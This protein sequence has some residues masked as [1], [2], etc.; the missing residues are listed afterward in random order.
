[1]DSG[2]IAD[3]SHETEYNWFDYFFSIF[4]FYYWKAVTGSQSSTILHFQF[5]MHAT[6]FM[7]SS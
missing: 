2:K 4:S 7:H 6:S 3:K 1:M 5:T